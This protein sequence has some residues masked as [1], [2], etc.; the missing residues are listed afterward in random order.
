MEFFITTCV[1]TS[2]PIKYNLI[3]CNKEKKYKKEEEDRNKQ[4]E[5]G[6]QENK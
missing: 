5:D 1:R 2:N 3:L 6:W 4:T